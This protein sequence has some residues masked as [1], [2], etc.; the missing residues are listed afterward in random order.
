MDYWAQTPLL[1]VLVGGL[2]AEPLKLATSPCAGL[3]PPYSH[4]GKTGDA[5]NCVLVFGRWSCD[6]YCILSR[7]VNGDLKKRPQQSNGKTS[8]SNVIPSY[9]PTTFN[10]V[11]CSFSLNHDFQAPNDPPDPQPV[12]SP[13]YS[14]L[15]LFLKDQLC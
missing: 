13:R 6:M 14:A 1:A 3:E 4:V 7:I 2:S 12:G 5:G 9:G 11:D 15:A 10:N 8:N